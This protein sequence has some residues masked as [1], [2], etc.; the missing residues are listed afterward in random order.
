MSTAFY[1]QKSRLLISKI[2]LF[3]IRYNWKEINYPSGK[4]GWEKLIIQQL[5]LILILL[6][7]IFDILCQSFL[8]FSW[9]PQEAF[10]IICIDEIYCCFFIFHPIRRSYI[11][12]TTIKIYFMEF[13]IQQINTIKNEIALFHRCF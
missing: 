4:D 7:L 1:C 11:W 6:G 13:I 12:S 9:F 2:K 10:I 5:L 8:I 3:I